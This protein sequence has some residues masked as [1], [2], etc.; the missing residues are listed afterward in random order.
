[1]KKR[2]RM[3]EKRI[4]AGVLSVAMMV[5][6]GSSAV[7]AAEE[8]SGLNTLSVYTAAD[9]STATWN[10]EKAQNYGA[11]KQIFV[12]NLVEPD[13]NNLVEVPL[14]M[15]LMFLKFNLNDIRENQLSDVVQY[16]LV[17]TYDGK[18]GGDK[19][20]PPEAIDEIGL[21]VTETDDWIEGTGAGTA[22]ASSGADG[23]NYESRPKVV[24]ADGDGKITR[25]DA[26]AVTSIEPAAAASGT[27]YEWDITECVKEALESGK[28]IL[29][30]MGGCLTGNSN[31]D[32]Q[33]RINFR[34][35]EYGSVSAPRI[36]IL[37]RADEAEQNLIMMD[38]DI[39][40]TDEYMAANREVTRGISLPAQEENG[41]LIT[42]N[43]KSD[44]I[45]RDG[46]V[47]Q[48]PSDTD[49][50]AVLEAV[51]RRE[52]VSRTKEYTILLK[53]EKSDYI[54]EETYRI[55]A[56]ADTSVY[57]WK[58]E[59]NQVYG[60][61][62][63]M[64]IHEYIRPAYNTLDWD[65]NNTE[66]MKAVYVR[67][68]IGDLCYLD[69]ITGVKLKLFCESKAKVTDNNRYLT[70]GVFEAD[71]QW[72]EETMNFISR[73]PIVDRNQ[74]GAI[75]G[76]DAITV[77]ETDAGSLTKGSLVEADLTDAIQQMVQNKQEMVTLCLGEL[78]D[79][80]QNLPR[81][82]FYTKES[83]DASCHPCLEVT[84]QVI[85][86]DYI[87][88]SQ[89]EANIANVKNEIDDYMETNASD[90]VVTNLA[91]PVGDG[92]YTFV[93]W[94]SS[95]PAVITSKG[96]IVRPG[97]DTA[98]TM[99]AVIRSGELVKTYSYVVTVRAKAASG[100]ASSGGSGGGFGF[101]AS[102]EEEQK[103]DD[104]TP[105]TPNGGNDNQ[106]G[107]E[108]EKPSA[109]NR[110][111]AVAAKYTLKMKQIKTINVRNVP[112]GAKVTYTSK[113]KKVVYVS[114]KGV[115]KG[116][117]AGTAKI[118]T[119]IKAGSKTYRYVTVVRVK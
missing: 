58:T 108:T 100:G 63:N 67:F 18:S 77:V 84:Y 28:D 119:K 97:T 118:V 107:T 31:E 90:A 51:F 46:T 32:I 1:M 16:K 83:G 66:D 43:S 49:E 114:K 101:I 33:Y 115:I 41:T 109:A 74:D 81:I 56:G 53:S 25:A 30:L 21:F 70:I 80:S 23:I 88:D 15:K 12:H 105:E 79:G 44:K 102:S 82:N 24:D 54:V 26:A 13:Y 99:T 52:G 29:S 10:T 89:A 113:N 96:N 93:T 106:N 6:T 40:R 14:D 48:R 7:Y 22:V 42:W 61:K 110:V 116:K 112:A 117:K 78:G 11:S 36:D 38:R 8:D 91:L 9:A 69:N 34:S 73:A 39:R 4:F 72:E 47:L 103:P 111:P 64:S 20:T 35:K 75:N 5:S 104:Q 87:T 2:N 95:D 86:E 68:P 3:I 76:E 57:T 45:D 59:K 60:N 62:A 85:D 37:Y 71:N 55:T 98:V 50:E 17:L 94:E 92:R 65:E 27:E 19:A